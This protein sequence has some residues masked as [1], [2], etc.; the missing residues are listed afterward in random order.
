MLEL[1]ISVN[2]LN[3]PIVL[4]FK[5]NVLRQTPYSTNDAK[6]T[7]YPLRILYKHLTNTDYKSVSHIVIL[8][9]CI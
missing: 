7:Y 2:L 6:S 8:I 9:W 5:I 3:I 1:T 4:V